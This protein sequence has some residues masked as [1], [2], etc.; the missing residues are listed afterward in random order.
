M[1]KHVRIPPNRAVVRFTLVALMVLAGV[2]VGQLA[3]A[4]AWGGGGGT[5]TT[6]GATTTTKVHHTTTSEATSTSGATTTTVKATTTSRETTSSSVGGTASSAPSS[7]I[8]G[9]TTT[10]AGGGLPFTG[11][12]SLPMLFVAL[13]LLALGGASLMAGSRRRHRA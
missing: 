13:A 1:T 10:Q 6:S 5:T 4:S 9:V 2:S 12:A 7:S 11:A 3:F 8:G